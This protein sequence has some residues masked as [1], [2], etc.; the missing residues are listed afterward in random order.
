M[1]PEYK[2]THRANKLVLGRGSALILCGWTPVEQLLKHLSPKDYACIGPLYSQDLGLTP[3]I[4][5]LLANPYTWTICLLSARLQDRITPGCTAFYRFL[6][7]HYYKA[8]DVYHVLDG[9]DGGEIGKFSGDFAEADLE[10]LRHNLLPTTMHFTDANTLINFAKRSRTTPQPYIEPKYYEIKEPVAEYLPGPQLNPKVEGNTISE[11][12]LKALYLI[13]KTG[14]KVPS[15]YAERQQLITLTS[16]IHNEPRDFHFEDWMPT[17]PSYMEKYLPQVLTNAGADLDSYTYGSRLT[18]YVEGNYTIDQIHDVAQKLAKTPDTS[19]A[20]ITTWMVEKDLYSS[21][22]PCL[23][24]VWF[25]ILDGQLIACPTFRSHDIYMAYCSNLMAIR[26]MQ[27]VVIGHIHTE[28]PGLSLVAGPMICTS[29]SAHVYDWSYLEV[30]RLIE[31]HYKARRQTYSDPVGNFLIEVAN[32]SISVTQTTPD[33]YVAKCYEGKDALKLVREIEL[34]N[35]M[36]ER[37]HIGY[38]GIE[39]AKAEQSLKDGGRGYTQ[40]R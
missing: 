14:H 39:L 28:R 18:Q 20:L 17:S 22:P 13:R 19:Q 10:T 16:V 31:E 12:W 6:Q 23:T 21:N 11:A 30:D 33:G 38:L 8:K 7:G 32:N 40:D 29:H 26:R 27:D 24:Q 3:L 25:Y 1:I 2:P 15:Q 5:N 4:A 35:P 34:A 36:I 37:A 9:E